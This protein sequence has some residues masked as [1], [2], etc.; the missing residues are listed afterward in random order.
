MFI[1]G[2]RLHRLIATYAVNLLYYDQW[3]LYKPYFYNLGWW[4]TFAQQHGPPRLG[5][6]ALVTRYVAAWSSWSNKVEA[7]Y[8]ASLVVLAAIAALVLKRRVFGPLA[9]TDA[10]IPIIFLSPIQNEIYLGSLNSSHGAWP[11]LLI[12]LYCLAW[13][14]QRA[15]LKYPLLVVLNFVL[16]FTCFGLFMGGVT[17]GLLA[18]E[19]CFNY[20]TPKRALASGISLL[21]AALS[22]AAFFVNYK[23]S[24]AVSCYTFPHSQPWKY[25]IFMALMLSKFCGIDF[26]VTPQLSFLSLA[27]GAVLLL[28]LLVAFSSHSWAW[29]KSR[30]TDGR[31]AVI[32]TLAGFCLLFAAN[33]AIGRLCLGLVT[34]QSS[35]Y[36]T[37][38]ATGLLAIYFFLLSP[39]LQHLFKSRLRLRAPGLVIFVQPSLSRRAAELFIIMFALLVLF[40][41]LPLKFDEAHPAYQF[42][43]FKSRW[44]DCYRRTEQIDFCNQYANGMVYPAPAQTQLKEKLDF[45]KQHRL[46]LYSKAQ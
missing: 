44:A 19:L 7:Y 15:I 46:N 12:V 6:G 25:P 4:Q 40:G 24:P 13:T 36:T 8:I 16:I 32:I 2:Y 43:L 11:L 37:Y 9:W 29:L 5:I 30:A 10:I 34:S 14:T 18:I 17:L 20:R 45:L 1:L 26:A 23:F 21:L 31:H 39:R 38:T 42:K 3:D 41:H 33:T 28:L 35:R 27:L 22:V